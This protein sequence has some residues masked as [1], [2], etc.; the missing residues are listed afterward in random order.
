MTITTSK[1]VW[2]LLLAGRILWASTG[3]NRS[4]FKEGTQSSLNGNT[5]VR[6]LIGRGEPSVEVTA[7]PGNLEFRSAQ[8][9]EWLPLGHHVK[10]FT[11]QGIEG[12]SWDVGRL[13]TLE[14]RPIGGALKFAGSVFHGSFVVHLFKKSL[15]VVNHVALDAYLEGILGGEMNS[16]WEEEAL[17][18]QAVASRTYTYF[19][20]AHPKSSMFDV[21]HTTQDQVYDGIG[22]SS[23][24]IHRAVRQ[25][26]DQVLSESGQ[27][28]KAYYHS[29]CGGRTETS[30]D[31]W[32][33]KQKTPSVTC[34]YCQMHP[35]VWK[36]RIPIHDVLKAFKIPFR[37]QVFSI[38]NVEKSPSGR[39]A[40]LKINAGDFEKTVSSDQFRSALGYQKIK[41]AYFDWKFRG[42]ELVFD[43]YGAGH[44]VGMCQWGARHL[45]QQG[46]DY[47]QILRHYY[48]E[49][50][51]LT[52][53]ND[54]KSESRSFRF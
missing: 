36:A 44:G 11:G 48:P 39:I 22:I 38:S 41:S 9:S 26:H 47:D 7:V 53:N 18:A 17:K 12:V 14:I 1:M 13:D 49:S 21:E 16:S 40:S 19:M 2:I 27:L 15:W 28:F 45:A 10:L 31:V 54:S 37:K 29:R 20:M 8:N 52:V 46:L 30:H 23:V 3:A 24:R 51:L 33:T 5:Q 4:D 25:T 6:V 35:F 42:N 32:K 50:Q 43:G 34:A